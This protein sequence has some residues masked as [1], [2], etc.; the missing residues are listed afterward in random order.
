[1]KHYI[2]TI[3]LRKITKYIDGYVLRCA[4]SK[5]DEKIESIW[6]IKYYIENNYIVNNKFKNIIKCFVNHIIN[7]NYQHCRN[8]K[9]NKRQIHLLCNIQKRYAKYFRTPSLLPELNASDFS[10]QPLSNRISSTQ[11]RFSEVMPMSFDVSFPNIVFPNIMF[12]R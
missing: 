12:P 7:I 4:L 1:M 10:I 6:T 8:L 2:T 9:E 11:Y 3:R 5:C